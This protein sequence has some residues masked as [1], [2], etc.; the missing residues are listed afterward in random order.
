MHR[1]KIMCLVCQKM[2]G[3]LHFV[4]VVANWWKINDSVSKFDAYYGIASQLRRLNNKRKYLSRCFNW[5]RQ[6]KQ[7]ISNF[8]WF[9]LKHFLFLFR[10]KLLINYRLKQFSN[11]LKVYFFWRNIAIR[12]TRQELNSN[13]DW[14]YNPRFRSKRLKWQKSYYW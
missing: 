11:A 7:K 6:T 14:L 8:G 5:W 1:K 2:S 3:F 13:I 9:T 12:R 4:F 10:K